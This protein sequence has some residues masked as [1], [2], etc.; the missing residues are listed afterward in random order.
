MTTAIWFSHEGKKYYAKL[1]CQNGST[2]VLEAKNE[3]GKNVE[4]SFIEESAIKANK[5]ISK[6]GYIPEPQEEAES[7][8]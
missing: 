6:W 4:P 1:A 7:E 8:E 2:R 3:E 5:R